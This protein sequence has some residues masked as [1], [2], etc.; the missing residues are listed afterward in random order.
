M[1]SSIGQHSLET[2]RFSAQAK[3]RV[4]TVALAMIGLGAVGL[5]AGFSSHQP[6]SSFFYSYLSGFIFWL[7]ICLGAL[8]F[9]LVQHLTR[10][11]WSVVV[12]RFAENIASVLPVFLVLFI[13]ILFSLFEHEQIIFPWLHHGHVSASKAKYL[14]ST[15]FI[16][17]ALFYFAFW[18]FASY[19]LRKLSIMQDQTG[20]PSIAGQLQTY[21]PPMV[22]A[23]GLTI[24]FAAFD[25]LMSLDPHWFSTIFGVYFFA[26]CAVSIFAVLSLI[27]IKANESHQM[28][29]I[30]SVE[31][32]HD[33]GKFLFGFT[34][35]WAY[36]AFSQFF[37]I[38][39]ANIPEE[40]I[41]YKHRF[42]GTWAD[43]SA[44]LLFGH[45]IFQFLLL[46]PRGSKRNGI[47]LKFAACWA[48]VF[49]YLDIYWLI[50]PNRDPHGVHFQ[51][52]DAGAFLFVGGVVIYMVA[53]Q[54]SKNH[55]IPIKDVRLQESLSFENY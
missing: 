3:N 50:M 18:S 27:L 25:W 55:L 2:L 23:F 17:R 26:G 12:R 33:V 42:E 34:V 48:L 41:F 28:R 9:V 7:S 10:A 39:Y 11:G 13:P 5:G 47:V 49:H 37:L 16:I 44:A 30:V 8:F 36:I 15:F 32:M 40:T 54:M 46:L 24:S 31:H 4:T 52:A 51:F 19:R 14:N 20:D 53:Q 21:A 43:A 29:H 1:H 45:F 35:F 6:L 22:L 38:W